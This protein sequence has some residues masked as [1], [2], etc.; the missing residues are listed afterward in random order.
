MEPADAGM[1]RQRGAESPHERCGERPLQLLARRPGT[2]IVNLTP[3]G[4]DVRRFARRALGPVVESHGYGFQDGGCLCFAMALREWA[5]GR[6]DLRAV[7]RD[8]RGGQAQ[9]V[10]AAGAGSCMDSD[11]LCTEAEMVE[12]MDRFEAPRRHRIG[13][14]DGAASERVIPRDAGLVAWLAQGMR[15]RLGNAADRL[16]EMESRRAGT[17]GMMGKCAAG[18]EGRRRLRSHGEVP[19]WGVEADDLVEAGQRTPGQDEETV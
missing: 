7:H 16:A 12:K 8:G 11:G 9:H 10:F 5:D 18:S 19:D 2:R 3:L 6:L 15:S 17:Q 14:Y 13:A 4:R 1:Q